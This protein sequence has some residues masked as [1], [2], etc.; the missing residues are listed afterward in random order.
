MTNW[1]PDTCDCN[2]LGIDFEKMTVKE[3]YACAEHSHLELGQVLAA[4]MA[5][6]IAAN[7]LKN[8]QN[9]PTEGE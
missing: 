6:N 9:S 7:A 8:A 1:K 5:K 2:F 3:V 4:A